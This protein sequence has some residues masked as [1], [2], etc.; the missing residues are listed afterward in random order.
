MILA[1]AL[2]QQTPAL[3]LDEPTNHLDIT[4]QIMLM[5]LVKNLD[6]TVISAIHDLNIAAAYCDRI[7]V[8]KDGVLEG[9]GTPGE[10][11]TPE[12]IRRI[13]KVESEVVY[14][15]QGENAYFVLIK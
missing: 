10:V 8:L 9:E 1:R 6:V 5:K 4:H 11:L 12:L 15:S 3:I 14:D 13:Y 2:A 7:Y